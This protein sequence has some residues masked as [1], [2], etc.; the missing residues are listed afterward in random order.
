MDIKDLRAGDVVKVISWEHERPEHWEEYGEMD[1]W[2]GAVVTIAEVLDSDEI[3]LEDDEGKWQWYP[4]DFEAVFR[5]PDNNPNVLYKS[6]A[7]QK[8]IAKLKK[9][10]L[11]LRT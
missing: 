4:W 1:D 11:K 2:C 8:K 7:W 5:L 10:A 3:F 9:K 6:W